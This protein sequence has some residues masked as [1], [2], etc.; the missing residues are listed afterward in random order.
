MSIP[1]SPFFPLTPSPHQV[2]LSYESDRPAD[3]EPEQPF[4]PKGGDLYICSET[5]TAARYAAGCVA[6]AV[7]AVLGGRV[8]SALAVVGVGGGGG[9]RV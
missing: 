6:E 3:V 4:F 8:T 2:D 7:R 1:T 5:A 9:F